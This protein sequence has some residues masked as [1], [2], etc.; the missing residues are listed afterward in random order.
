MV[1]RSVHSSGCACGAIRHD[2]GNATALG[3]A[4]WL[5]LAAAPTF[6]IMALLTGVFGGGPPDM[7][8]SAVQNPSPLGGMVPMYVLMS[9]FHSSPWLTLITSAAAK[10]PP[11]HSSL[12]SR[13]QRNWGGEGTRIER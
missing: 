13:P 5:C 7:F 8:C 10:S 1:T 11:A 12:N 9:I 2:S 3:A 4:D 6:A